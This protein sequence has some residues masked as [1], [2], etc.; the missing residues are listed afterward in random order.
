MSSSKEFGA[1]K[2]GHDGVVAVK[3]TFCMIAAHFF[4]QIPRRN[5]DA[6]PRDRRNMNDIPSSGCAA[7]LLNIG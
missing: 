3:P 1:V 4:D 6:L 2:I 5:S 7:T